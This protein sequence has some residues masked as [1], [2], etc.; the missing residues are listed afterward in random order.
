MKEILINL[1]QQKVDDLKVGNSNI[2]E[3]GCLKVLHAL[4]LISNGDTVMSKVEACDYLGISR[5]SFD[6]LVSDGFIP[7]GQKLHE[8]SKSLFWY[9]SVLDDYLGTLHNKN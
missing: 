3:D 4:D 7:K 5:S 6:L 2:D 8:G 9:K 1:L